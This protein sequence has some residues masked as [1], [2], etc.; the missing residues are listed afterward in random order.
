[1]LNA[2]DLKN[3]TT[4]LSGG[5]PF[6]VIKYSLVKMGRGGATVKVN[7]K[8]LITGTVEDKSF[9]SN[10]KVEEVSTKKRKLQFLYK[11]GENAVFMDPDSYE[12]VEIPVKVVKDE[13][14]Y[15]KEGES[16]DILFWDEKPLSCEIAPKVVLK[17]INTV[18]GVK[19]NSASNV[20][21]DALLENGLS[22][23]VP[24]FIKKGEDIRIDTRDG[25]YVERASKS[26]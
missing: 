14:L 20:Y 15:I 25:S 11:D 2:T 10:I 21:K 26:S 18:P 6:K 19:G 4:F 1:M 3:G 5:A 8:N 12:Q 23:K 16:I 22:V 7:A 17:V 13:L 24:L 9:S